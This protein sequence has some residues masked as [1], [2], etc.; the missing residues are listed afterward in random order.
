MPELLELVEKINFE[1]V[2]AV[3]FNGEKGTPLSV[4]YKNKSSAV[5]L[6]LINR[7]GG[8]NQHRLEKKQ[9]KKKLAEEKPKLTKYI[10]YILTEKTIRY[11][12][13]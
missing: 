1:H 9:N 7:I 8:W 4:L 10:N 11:I 12:V 2:S 13:T 5:D 3:M 6:A